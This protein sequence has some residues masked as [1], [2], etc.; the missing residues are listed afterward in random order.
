VQFVKDTQV[1]GL[2]VGHPPE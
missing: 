2:W 1:S